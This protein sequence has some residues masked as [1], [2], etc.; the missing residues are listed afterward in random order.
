MVGWGRRSI[1]RQLV[2]FGCWPSERIGLNWPFS[3]VCTRQVSWFSLQNK[4][5]HFS[6]LQQSNNDMRPEGP[7]SLRQFQ[8]LLA[9]QISLSSLYT[10][11][12]PSRQTGITQ[13]S[14]KPTLTSE[15]K[16]VPETPF[17]L[18]QGFWLNR[19]LNPIAWRVTP[20]LCLKKDF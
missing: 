8:D 2:H 6:F 14:Q 15:P 9:L 7:L 19:E 20:L 12:P 16:A 5:T 4:N 17:V 11:P 10:G 1:K 13:R 18:S 3:R